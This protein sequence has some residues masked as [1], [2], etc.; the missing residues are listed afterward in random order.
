MLAAVLVVDK[1]V[2]GS[3]ND[4]I[5]DQ[6]VPAAKEAFE[7]LMPAALDKAQ[8][9]YDYFNDN[10]WIPRFR[11]EFTKKGRWCFRIATG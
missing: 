4:A 6:L 7:I 1:A 5:I 8:R 2:A 10:R 9:L 3:W 11:V